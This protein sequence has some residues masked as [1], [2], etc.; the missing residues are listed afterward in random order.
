MF[1]QVIAFENIG[2]CVL[3]GE[4]L[5]SGTAA[6]QAAGRRT[7]RKQHFL[8][9]VHTKPSKEDLQT[10]GGVRLWYL[11]KELKQDSR[12]IERQ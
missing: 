12:N 5:L 11:G 7:G 3:F 1:Q 9:A 2:T 10:R 8:N 6:G 4:Q